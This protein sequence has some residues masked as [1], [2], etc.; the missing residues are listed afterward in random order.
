MITENE[1]TMTD[2]TKAAAYRVAIMGCL[3]FWA[4]L[5]AVL[6]WGV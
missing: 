5:I 2:K 6:V 3:L 4:A 1:A